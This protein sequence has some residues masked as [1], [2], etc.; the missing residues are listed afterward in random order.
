MVPGGFNVIHLYVR[1]MK[2]VEE[3]KICK[4]RVH[5]ESFIVVGPIGMNTDMSRVLV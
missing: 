3:R 5:K 4:I 2:C 1:V